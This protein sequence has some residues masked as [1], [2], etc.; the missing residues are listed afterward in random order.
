MSIPSAF[1]NAFRICFRHPAD[2]L[3]FLATELCLVLICLAPLLFLADMQIWY[4]AVLAVPLWILVM[5]PARMNAAEAMQDS[6][7]GGRLFSLR[8]ADP[9]DWRDKVLCGLKRTV[10]LLLWAS[11]LIA[12]AVY[13]WRHFSGLVDG[14]TLLAMIKQF[15]GGDFT[16]E[17]LE[18]VKEA[19]PKNLHAVRLHQMLPGMKATAE[20]ADLPNFSAR[21]MNGRP[22]SS[23]TYK[24]AEVAVIVQWASWNYESLNMLRDV[25]RISRK[26]SGRLKVLSISMDAGVPECK[27]PLESDSLLWPNVCDGMMFDGDLTRSLALTSVPDN[28]VLQRGRVV[29]RSLPASN[30]RNKLEKLLNVDN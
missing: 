1:R 2:T 9:A 3:K 25:K 30:L 20:K 28:I 4:P 8:L 23:S 22:V 24:S 21:D 29:G 17:L 19:Q 13:A 5:F 7:R 16:S 11:P 12:A 18:L 6:L 10:F 26:A 15:G 27:K 14:F